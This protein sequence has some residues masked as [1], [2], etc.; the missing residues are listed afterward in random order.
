M[1]DAGWFLLF[2]LFALAGAA[3]LLF[4]VPLTER[5]SRRMAAASFGL[6]AAAL[7]AIVAAAATGPW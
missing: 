4:S 7:I 6:I 3:A 2:S 5:H 1:T